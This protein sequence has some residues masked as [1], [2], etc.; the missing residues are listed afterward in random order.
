[1]LA[2][3][4]HITKETHYDVFVINLNKIHLILLH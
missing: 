3:A 4:A 2:K 1:M